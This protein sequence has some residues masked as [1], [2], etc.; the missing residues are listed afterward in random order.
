MGRFPNSVSWTPAHDDPAQA[1]SYSE[2]AAGHA[3]FLPL[4]YTP[5]YQYPLLIWLHSNGFNENQL[6][7][8]MPYISLRNYVGVGVRATKAADAIGHR[9]DW[10]Q[11]TA[12]IAAAHDAIITA[13]DEASERF[14]VNSDRIILAGYRDGGTMAL[15]IA[16]RQ[17][18]RFA[19]AVSLG[20]AMP[21]GAIRNIIELRE[22]RLPMLWQWGGARQDFTSDLLKSDCR[23][24]MSIGGQVEVRQYPGDDE[25][26]TVV[27]KDID[28][29][30]M[31]RIVSR[32]STSTSDRWASSPTAYSAN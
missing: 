3:F 4:H 16:M 5:T 25:M 2:V 31:R 23:M 15:R 22:K 29:W 20:G 24:A 1:T 11:G 9:F 12:A 32:S 30:I 17:P 19:A 27:L 6:D 8:V 26:D 28:D 10:H 13:V 21:H 14:S 18:K 7:D